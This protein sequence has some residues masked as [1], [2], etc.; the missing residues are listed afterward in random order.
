MSED[1]LLRDGIGEE[2]RSTFSLDHVQGG[3]K[4]VGD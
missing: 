4:R 1:E 3:V 2:D